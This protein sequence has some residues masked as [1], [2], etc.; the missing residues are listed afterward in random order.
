MK[1]KINIWNGSGWNHYAALRELKSLK[2]GSHG[3]ASRQGIA[4]IE[5]APRDSE[6]PFGMAARY[7]DAEGELMFTQGF[8]QNDSANHIREC[9]FAL[10]TD[11]VQN[12]IN[13]R[14]AKIYRENFIHKISAWRRN[15][16]EKTPISNSI[17][18]LSVKFHCARKNALSEN[19]RPSRKLCTTLAW[20]VCAG[21]TTFKDAVAKITAAGGRF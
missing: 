16:D 3:L 13:N 21:Q 11:G 4:K 1:I 7:Y 14:A 8:D 5:V 18:K 10:L 6:K 17:E 19:F 9:V 15:W 12:C 2:V 20:E